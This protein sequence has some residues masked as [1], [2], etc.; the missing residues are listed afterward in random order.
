MAL[1]GLIDHDRL[2]GVSNFAIGKT[3][4]LTV[5][6]EYGIKDHAENVLVVPTDADALKKFNKN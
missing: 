6:E 2:D 1:Y 3:R 4:I 5:L